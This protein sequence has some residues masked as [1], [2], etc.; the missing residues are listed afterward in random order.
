MIYGGDGLARSPEGKTVF[1][2]LVLPG[3]EV[4]A[5]VTEEK[6]G[7]MRANL[8]QLLKASPQRIEASCPY[9]GRGGGCHYQ[10]T[11]YQA[12]LEFKQA[13]LRETFRRTAKFE[14]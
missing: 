10:H 8:D 3:E 2:P 12:Q 6:S 9:F 5:T 14:W 7:F 13:I 1:V 11:G 4:S